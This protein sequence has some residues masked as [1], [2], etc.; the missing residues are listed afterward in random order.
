MFIGR[1][2]ELERM[3]ERYNRGGFECLPIYG[4]RRV[5]KTAL[6]K[7][8][9][10][11]KKAIFF[12]ATENNK[13]HNLQLL[14]S[15]IF[16]IV[17]GIE[18][19]ITYNSF[20]AAFDII[21]ELAKKEKIV[22][23]IDEYPYLAQSYKPVSSILQSHIDH[24]FKDT[25]I[26]IILC[27]SSMSFMEYQVLGYKSPLY[28]RRT[29]QFKIEPFNFKYSTKFHKTFS[30]EE[31][32]IIYGITGGIPQYLE[33]MD[34]NRSLKENIIEN[35]YGIATKINKE[36]KEIREQKRIKA[37]KLCL[38]LTYFTCSYILFTVASAAGRCL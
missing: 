8:F 15:A 12:T 38:F 11:D 18:S 17:S 34:E 21:F 29:G 26:F 27:G 31:K 2:H 14:S 20:E 22:F 6:I 36:R 37:V 7:E 9:I 10:K 24:K 5:G 32:A 4:R 23:V 16:E 35:I 13:N 30:K 25:D 1:E 19:T 28:G 33:M 3:N